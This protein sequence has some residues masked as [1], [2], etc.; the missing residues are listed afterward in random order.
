LEISNAVGGLKVWQ[1]AS[2]Q[3]NA[4]FVQG[5][6]GVYLLAIKERAHR[7]SRPPLC[8]SPARPTYCLSQP[9]VALEAYGSSKPSARPS[10]R[11]KESSAQGSHGSSSAEWCQPRPSPCMFAAELWS[12]VKLSISELE[13][14]TR[15]SAAFVLV[16]LGGELKLR[17]HVFSLG[18]VMHPYC[19]NVFKRCWC[20]GGREPAAG[21]PHRASQCLATRLRPSARC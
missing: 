17:V 19:S 13:L 1:R 21:E 6:G 14:G 18:G 3:P 2:R 10:R 9:P 20:A 16:E 11:L 4:A 5:D 7:R 15:T 8:G 12:C